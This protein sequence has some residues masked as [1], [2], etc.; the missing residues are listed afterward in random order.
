[1]NSNEG[2]AFLPWQDPQSKRYAFGTFSKTE[3]ENLHDV[4]GFVAIGPMASDWSIIPITV[5]SS[6]KTI[7]SGGFNLSSS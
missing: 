6:Q 4:G 7:K 2:A 5:V 1:M 3:L